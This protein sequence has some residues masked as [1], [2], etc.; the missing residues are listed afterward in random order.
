MLNIDYKKSF[1]KAISK[2]K[3][4]AD[5]TRV[6]KQIEKVIEFPNIGKPMKY[7]RKGTRE[8]YI[9]S[10]RLAYS[11]SLSENKITFLDIYHKD[12]Q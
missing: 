6:K 8:L 7:G 12:E 4:Q 9:S 11:F 2:I 10:Y 3:N 1:L 5:K